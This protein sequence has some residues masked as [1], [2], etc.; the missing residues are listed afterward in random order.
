MYQYWPNATRLCINPTGTEEHL[1]TYDSADDLKTAVRQFAIWRDHCHY[2]LTRCWV[3]VYKDGHK[4]DTI[5]E[6]D[7]P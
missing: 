2:K 6:E 5:R 7:L 4:I 3:D 1:S